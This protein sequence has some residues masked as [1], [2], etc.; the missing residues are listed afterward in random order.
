MNKSN[1][2]LARTTAVFALFCAS[3]GANAAEVQAVG[4]VESIAGRAA[5]IKV[6][7]QTFRATP[8]L[9]KKAGALNVGDYVAVSGEMTADGSLIA[10]SVVRVDAAY[11][12]GASEVFLHSMVESYSPL[13]GVLK[14]GGV[15]IALSQVL[16]GNLSSF[17][18]GE[19]VEIVGTQ[20][21][22]GGVVWAT[23]L[24]VDPVGSDQAE[25]LSIQGTGAN[26]LSIQGTGANTLSIQ[27]TGASK[28]SIQGTGKQSIQGTGANTLSIQGTGKQ[29]IQGT[30][31][32]TLSIQGTGKQSIQGTGASTLSIQGTGA[33]TLSIQGTGA[34]ALSIQGTG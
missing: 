18:P 23:A 29:S 28:L 8:A 4:P 31:A 13:T 34:A 3:V 2:K 1:N 30:G 19:V 17:R 26:A 11:T 20:A 33:N 7:G 14:A 16:T 27:G 15:Q 5:S 12:P 24:Q 22:A 9:S 21:L 10:K 6:L 32:S 25:S